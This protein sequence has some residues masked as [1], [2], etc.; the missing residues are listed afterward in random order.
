MSLK[1]FYRKAAKNSLKL[2]AP[3]IKNDRWFVTVMYKLRTG[4]RLD[5]DNP[6]TLNEKIQWLKIYN[7]HDRQTA[8]V[9]KLA[10]KDIVGDIIGREYIIPTI[11]TWKS[12]DD[13]DFDALPDRFVLKTSHGWGGKGVVICKDKAALDREKARKVIDHSMHKRNYAKLR[14]WPYKNIVPTVLAE[15]YIGT[16]AEPVPTDYKFFCFNGRAE[17]VMVCRGRV[18]GKNKPRYYFFDRE[19]RFKP[20]N[21]VDADTP[22]DFTLPKPARIDEMFAIAN[23]LCKEE[24]QI[25]I[26][27]Y[28]VEDR[29]YFGEMTYFNS[30]GY[31]ND[32]SEE[33]DR[34]FGSLFTLPEPSYKP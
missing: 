30:S 14:E 3:L 24:P 27:L 7:R 18:P 25:R 20:F 12:A 1:A 26:D 28:Y 6:Q 11:A 4:R 5:L 23:R 10:V 2:I 22:A 32:I 13:I 19:W 33:T 31:D 21:K 15:E 16:E 9:D 29:I 17:Y 8:L 34:Y